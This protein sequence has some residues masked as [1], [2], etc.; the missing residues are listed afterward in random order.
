VLRIVM[1]VLPGHYHAPK[2]IGL[3][4]AQV[5]VKSAGSG[6]LEIVLRIR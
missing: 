2:R 5:R 1:D 6:C 3:S 4:G